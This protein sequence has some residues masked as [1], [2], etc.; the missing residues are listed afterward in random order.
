MTPKQPPLDPRR[1]GD[2]L[3]AVRRCRFWMPLAS[4]IGAQEPESPLPT[5][6]S[7]ALHGERAAEIWRA[8]CQLPDTLRATLVLRYYV[9]LTEEEMARTLSVSTGT[10]KSRLSRARDRLRS[11]LPSLLKEEERN[12]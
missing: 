2:P 3:R 7:A 5:P 12:A 1:R 4:L 9:G 10:V 8:V 6:E 11:T